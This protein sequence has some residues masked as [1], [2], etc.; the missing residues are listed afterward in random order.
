MPL[1]FGALAVTDAQNRRGDY[2]KKNC[3]NRRLEL[4]LEEKKEEVIK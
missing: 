1:P 2:E 4:E 3:L